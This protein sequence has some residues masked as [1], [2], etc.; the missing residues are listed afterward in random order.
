MLRQKEVHAESTRFLD[1]SVLDCYLRIGQFFKYAK[2]A[3]SRRR[4]AKNDERKG[5]FKVIFTICSKIMG[6][7][8]VLVDDALIRVELFEGIVTCVM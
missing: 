6:L 8:R 7:F 1:L 3:I 4:N 2:I 5:V